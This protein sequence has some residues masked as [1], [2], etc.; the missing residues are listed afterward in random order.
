MNKEE[1]LKIIEKSEESIGW[2]ERIGSEGDNGRCSGCQHL[3]ESGSDLFGCSFTCMKG[4]SVSD[5]HYSKYSED[6]NDY[7]KDCS[8]FE[9]CRHSGIKPDAY[10]KIFNEKCQ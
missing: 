2:S 8:S 5:H 4:H 6:S 10:E 3:M 7:Y 9:K 1:E